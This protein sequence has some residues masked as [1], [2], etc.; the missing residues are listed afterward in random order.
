M[1]KSNELQI[2]KAGEYLVCCDLIMKGYVAFISEQGLPYDVVLDDGNRMYRVQ[3]KSNLTYKKTPQRATE[4]MIYIFNVKRRGKNNTQKYTSG[5]VDIFAL[6]GLDSKIVAYLPNK[7]VVETMNFRVP[8]MRGSYYDEQGTQLKQR[9]LDLRAQGKSCQEISETL[10]MKRATV[11]RY[12]GN[13]NISPKGHVR[14]VY[15]D[16]FP[17]ENCLCLLR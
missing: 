16:G 7:Q 5:D 9:V 3:V 15:L 17:I 12:S 2:G 1:R 8:S 13:L 14:P 4:R 6:V 10:K 11:Y